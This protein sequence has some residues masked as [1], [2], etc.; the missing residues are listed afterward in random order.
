MISDLY[1]VNK[2]SG[3]TKVHSH[4]EQ[5]NCFKD[6]MDFSLFIFKLRNMKSIFNLKIIPTLSQLFLYV[7]ALIIYSLCCARSKGHHGS[8]E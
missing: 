3:F 1:R 4:F 7:D 2:Q 6:K 5:Y 8:Y